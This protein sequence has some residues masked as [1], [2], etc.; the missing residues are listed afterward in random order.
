MFD[1]GFFELTLIGVVALIVVGPERLPALARTVGLWVGKARRM[2]SQ[3]REDVERELRAD[4]VRQML[5]EHPEIEEV[6]GVL[7][8]TGNRVKSAGDELGRDVSESG[9]E[10]S[11]KAQGGQGEASAGEPSRPATAATAKDED[12]EQRDV[13]DA[14]ASGEAPVPAVRQPGEDAARAAAGGEESDAPARSGTAPGTSSDERRTSG[15]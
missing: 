14:G 12:G 11:G 2:V 10:P 8:E 6:G 5:K 3:V 7:R 15:D 4:E 9:D 13:K 1:I